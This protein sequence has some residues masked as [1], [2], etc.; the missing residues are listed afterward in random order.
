MLSMMPK[1]SK[2]TALRPNFRPVY[3]MAFAGFTDS[4]PGGGIFCGQWGAGDG[5]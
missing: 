2:P 3:R 4:R 1:H 5:G